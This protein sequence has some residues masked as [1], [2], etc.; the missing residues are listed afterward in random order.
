MQ[1]CNIGTTSPLR[2]PGC[3]RSAAPEVERLEEADLPE[4]ELRE[5][6]LLLPVLADLPAP[7]EVVDVGTGKGEEV[8]SDGS[9]TRAALGA[10]RDRLAGGEEPDPLGLR[11][12]EP[13]LDECVDGGGV[14]VP[15]PHAAL[16]RVSEP[17]GDVDAERGVERAVRVGHAEVDG[18]VAVGVLLVLPEDG[19]NLRH[20][21][22]EAVRRVYKWYDQREPNGCHSR[23]RLT[24]P[25]PWGPQGRPRSNGAAL[26]KR[27][28]KSHPSGS[29][30]VSKLQRRQHDVVEV[31]TVTLS[32]LHLSLDGRYHVRREIN[33]GDMLD[34]S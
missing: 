18:V 12:G 3:L 30:T 2:S 8:A 29:R 7:P 10:S 11:L 19:G 6:R 13:L 15:P 16:V 34:A 21:S 33:A 28:A 20:G 5:H 14:G 1:G 22:G 26:K 31:L 25:P 9:G 24:T 23:A 4:R 27:T 17:G 32:D